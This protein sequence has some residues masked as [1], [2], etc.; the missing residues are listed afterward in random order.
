MYRF[1]ITGRIKPYVRMTQRGKWVKPQAIE[2]QASKSALQYQLSAQMAQH[3]WDTLPGQTPLAMHLVLG[4][5]RHS[6]DLDNIIKAVADAANGVVYP[7]D[8]W[9]DRITA[10]RIG[11]PRD[12]EQTVLT[13]TILYD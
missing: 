6:Q 5:R 9:I 13:V 11:G 8:R 4:Y 12:D 3:G 1:I 7:D 10:E 2:Y